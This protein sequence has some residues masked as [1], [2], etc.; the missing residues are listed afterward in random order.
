MKIK[1]SEI[2]YERKNT[3]NEEDVNI[4]KDRKAC[5]RLLLI[6]MDKIYLIVLV[7]T[8]LDNCVK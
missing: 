2:S 4:K 1:F 3:S 8:D 5:I 6:H 7:V